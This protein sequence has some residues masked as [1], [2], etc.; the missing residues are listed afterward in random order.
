M[1]QYKRHPV[2]V[3]GGG[4]ARTH[5]LVSNELH[6]QLHSQEHAPN[7]VPAYNA[8]MQLLKTRYTYG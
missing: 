7:A 4:H 2:S 6:Q 5:L 3:G 1:S 8:Y